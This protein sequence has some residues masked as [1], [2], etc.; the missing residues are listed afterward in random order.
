MHFWKKT[1]DQYNKPCFVGQHAYRSFI[2]L[3]HKSSSPHVGMSF[4]TLGHIFLSPN[5]PC[6]NLSRNDNM[7]GG[8]A[9]TSNFRV[10]D[11]IQPG[12]EPMTF[13]SQVKQ[14]FYYKTTEAV[15]VQIRM[16]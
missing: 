9:M 7:I 12:F 8:E 15:K 1:F 16:I 2:V 6:I 10:Y 4:I 13:R 5:K 3:S 11:V 14:Q